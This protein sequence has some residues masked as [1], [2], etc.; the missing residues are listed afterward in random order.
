MPDRCEV[1]S[2]ERLHTDVVSVSE[3]RRSLVNVPAE[4]TVHPLIIC[5][6]RRLQRAEKPLVKA[7]SRVSESDFMVLEDENSRVHLVGD[8]LHVSQLSTGVVCGVMGHAQENGDFQ[9][10]VT[11]GSQLSFQ[12]HHSL[13]TM[14]SGSLLLRQFRPAVPPCIQVSKLFFPAPNAQLARPLPPAGGP[15]RMLALVSGLKVCAC[16]PH[17]TASDC[18][19]GSPTPV[20]L[21]HPPLVVFAALALDS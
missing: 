21:F 16:R 10:P 12:R 13:S 11:L 15:R 14:H 6:P 9:V 5:S 17:P 20:R 19:R 18:Q 4:C 8:A 7:A 1:E 2:S 3:T